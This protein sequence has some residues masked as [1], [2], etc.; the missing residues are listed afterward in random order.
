QWGREEETAQRLIDEFSP[1]LLVIGIRNDNFLTSTWDDHGM[2]YEL[3][4]NR[5][6]LTVRQNNAFVTLRKMVILS[7]TFDRLSD[8]AIDIISSL[9]E[10][11]GIEFDILQTHK[12]AGF[13]SAVKA[14]LA[15]VNTEIRYRIQSYQLPS[16]R[17]DLSDVH[18]LYPSDIIMVDTTRRSAHFWS[19]LIHPKG[20]KHQ[21]TFCGPV[22]VITLRS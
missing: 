20:P 7:D 8:S 11:G 21:T 16:L 4:C 12:N 15:V 19:R 17:S 3:D 18:T 22:P 2:A 10:R 1:D 6:V 13:L 14:Q 9:Q 5:P